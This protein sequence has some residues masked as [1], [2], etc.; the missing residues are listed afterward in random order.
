MKKAEKKIPKKVSKKSTPAPVSFVDVPQSLAMVIDGQSVPALWK[1]NKETGEPGFKTGSKGWSA[2]G[3]I[4][5]AGHRC[6]VS[7]NII[8]IGTKPEA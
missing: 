8:I 6:Q 3:K 5:V 1:I 7:C 4:V 2:M